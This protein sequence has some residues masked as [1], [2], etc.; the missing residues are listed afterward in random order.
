MTP[1]CPRYEVRRIPGEWA[2]LGGSH[3]D[4]LFQ[5]WGWRDGQR[6]DLFPFTEC[7]GRTWME[8][9]NGWQGLICQRQ[10]GGGP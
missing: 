10:R 8:L 4:P 5:V 9:P 2:R 7:S 3:V 1:V 6:R